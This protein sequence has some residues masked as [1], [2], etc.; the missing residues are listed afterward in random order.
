MKSSV[1][2]HVIEQRAEREVLAFFIGLDFCFK[3][4]LAIH[5]MDR[6]G[7]SPWLE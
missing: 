6:K 3:L 1:Y 4:N 2:H 7:I 5:Q